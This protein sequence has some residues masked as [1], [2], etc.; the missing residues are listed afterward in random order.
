[1]LN[2]SKMVTNNPPPHSSAQYRI[3][4]TP[5]TF[6]AKVLKSLLRTDINKY[7]SQILRGYEKLQLKQKYK[8]YFAM[9]DRLPYSNRNKETG[10]LAECQ[11]VSKET[12]NKG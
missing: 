4:L 8:S 9:P 10:Q 2:T 6:H 1:M 11:L 7:R 12:C 5:P 3:S